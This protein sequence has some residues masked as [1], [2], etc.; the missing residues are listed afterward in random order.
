MKDSG[1]GGPSRHYHPNTLRHDI[2]LTQQRQR[3]DAEV[4]KAMEDEIDDCRNHGQPLV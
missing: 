2:G 3:R 4:L 1:S